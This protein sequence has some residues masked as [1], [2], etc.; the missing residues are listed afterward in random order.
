M[1]ILYCTLAIPIDGAH[2]GA[3]HA[4]EVANGLA[5]LGHDVWVVGRGSD[6]EAAA[7]RF[8]ARVTLTAAPP[9]LAWQLA[10]RV[11]RTRSWSGSTPSRARGCSSRTSAAS[12]P[13]LK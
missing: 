5:A 12:R 8:H 11:R 2:G 1:R 13:C 3:T 7:R 4:A 6:R 10:P 9:P